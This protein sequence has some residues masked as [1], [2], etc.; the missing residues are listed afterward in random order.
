MEGAKLGGS[1]DL[2]DGQLVYHM[3]NQHAFQFDTMNQ[4]QYADSVSVMED[5]LFA[6]RGQLDALDCSDLE[7]TTESLLKYA[8]VGITQGCIASAMI[9]QDLDEF[10]TSKTLAEAEG[11]ALSILPLIHNADPE[12]ATSIERNMIRQSGEEPVPD[13]GQAVGKL[14]GQGFAKALLLHCSNLG[15]LPTVDP[16]EGVVCPECSGPVTKA[17]GSAAPR[18]VTTALMGGALAFLVAC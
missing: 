3:A 12:L 7:V 8:M 4:Y 1:E 14:F 16:C 5:L 17:G 11:L 15:S 9:N 13:G 2:Q 10:S 6:A 18:R